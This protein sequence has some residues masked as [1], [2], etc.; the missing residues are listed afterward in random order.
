MGLGLYFMNPY[1]TIQHIEVEGK[2]KYYFKNIY[3]Q[4][5][6]IPFYFKYLPQH[7]VWHNWLSSGIQMGAKRSDLSINTPIPGKLYSF[8]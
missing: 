2:N 1:K 4:Q 3:K 7:Y 6:E 8:F 5:M